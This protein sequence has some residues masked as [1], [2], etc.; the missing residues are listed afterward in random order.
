MPIDI[1]SNELGLDEIVMRDC[2]FHLERMDDQCF[3]I[4]IDNRA[5]GLY[6]INIYLEDG[7]LVARI[8]KQ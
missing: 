3:W 8:E 1:E 6:H 7:K 5:D 2:F 4:G